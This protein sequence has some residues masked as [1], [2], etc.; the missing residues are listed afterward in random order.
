MRQ[1]LLAKKVMARAWNPPWSESFLHLYVYYSRR[2]EEC[3]FIVV[4]H[5]FSLFACRP[6]FLW[7]SNKVPDLP[8]QG[9]SRDVGGSGCFWQP[10]GQLASRSYHII[11]EVEDESDAISNMYSST[12]LPCLTG[13]VGMDW[14]HMQSWI[15]HQQCCF[16]SSLCTSTNVLG[17]YLATKSPK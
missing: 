8:G 17:N 13:I 3:S 10:A 9:R 1:I 12:A 15:G 4:C 7:L 16:G 6:L 2:D 14:S 5:V 11:L